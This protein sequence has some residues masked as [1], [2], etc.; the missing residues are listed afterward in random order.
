MFRRSAL[1]MRVLVLAPIGRDAALLAATLAALQIE[2]AISNNTTTL[3]RLLEEGA[4]SAIITEEAL[5]PDLIHGLA[6]WLNVQ[7]PWSDTPFIVLTSGG[8][9]TPESH[10]RAQE[11]QKLGNFT[12]LERPVRPETVQSSIRAALRARMRQYEIR[13]R[14]EALLQA[15]ADLEQ[16]AYSA[17]HDLKEPIRTISIYSELL[18]KSYG[19]LLEDRGREFLAYIQSGAKRMDALLSDLLS[20]AHASSISEGAVEPVQAVRP[21]EA[22]LESLAGAIRES[23]AQILVGEMPVV[24]MHESHLSQIFQNLIGNAIKYRKAN[25]RLVIEVSARRADSL[26]IFRIADNGIGVPLAYKE[27]I[28]GIFKRLHTNSEYSGTGMGLAICKRI[29]ERYG[30]RIWVE[31]EPEHGSSFLFTIR[32]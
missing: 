7:P 6:K 2:T 25:E 28:F 29:I 23:D 14:Q 31:S 24:R 19:T 21:L 15:N 22:A 32:S 10:R 11:L 26:W 18:A 13:S 20:Y 4:G 12:L 9:T 1:E 17:S 16:F 5:M 3:L 30:G 27:T 8:R